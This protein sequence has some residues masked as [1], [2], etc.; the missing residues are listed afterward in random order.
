VN[1]CKTGVQQKHLLDLGQSPEHEIIARGEV[2]RNIAI[3]QQTRARASLS[4]EAV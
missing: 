3:F 4:K 1:V 2:G